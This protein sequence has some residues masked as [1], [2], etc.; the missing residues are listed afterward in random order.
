MGIKAITV[1]GIDDE[2]SSKLKQI[3]KRENKSVNRFILDMIKQNIGVQK[4]YRKE[5]HDLDHLFGKW[6]NDEFSKIQKIIESQRKIDNDL[7][8]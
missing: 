8:K 6:T 1:R 4:K 2:V 7:W 3:A 5:Y